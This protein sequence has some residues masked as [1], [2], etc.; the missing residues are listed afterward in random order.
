MNATA[1]KEYYNDR[2]DYMSVVRQRHD[3][4]IQSIL[5]L[6]KPSDSVLD[7][8]CGTG[9]TTN[10]ISKKASYTVGVDLSDKLIEKGKELYPTVKFVCGD[11]SDIDLVMKFD[12]VCLVDVLEHVLPA[13]I[14]KFMNNIAKHTKGMIYL[15][16]PD[17]RYLEYLRMYKPNLLQIVDEPYRIERIIEMFADIGFTPI[18]INIYGNNIP[19]YNEFVFIPYKRLDDQYAKL[20]EGL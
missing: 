16:I 4:V 5:R 19:E 8:G 13:R 18:G 11:F 10:G 14:P 6:I 12:L 1:V 15:N 3:I 20:T 17:G 2:V 7:V 9:I